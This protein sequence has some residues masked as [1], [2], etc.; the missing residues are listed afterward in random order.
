M[1]MEQLGLLDQIKKTKDEW[2][3]ASITSTVL[4]VTMAGITMK[5]L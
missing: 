4:S 2:R 1:S 3:F 5:L